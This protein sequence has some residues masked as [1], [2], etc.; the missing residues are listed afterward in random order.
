[1]GFSF[2]TPIGEDWY[3]GFR[4]NSLMYLK[5]TDPSK[6]SFFAGATEVQ[7]ESESKTDKDLLDY[8]KS[9]KQIKD[10]S[11]F[12]N[13]TSKLSINKLNGIV[14]VNYKEQ[15]E[16]HKAKNLG[17][18]KFLIMTNA[19]RI[20]MEPKEKNKLVDIHY[21]VRSVPNL[22]IDSFVSE[23]DKFINSLVHKS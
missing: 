20:C 13:Q 15:A 1:M 17:S 5:Q 21:S 2:T 19:G 6:L 18:H 22:N 10:K 12:K 11:R 9:Y 3:E 23:G 7:F 14:C 8:V 16:D 4:A